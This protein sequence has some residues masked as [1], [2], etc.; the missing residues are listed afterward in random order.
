VDVMMKSSTSKRNAKEYMVKCIEQS[1]DMLRQAQTQINE[2]YLIYTIKQCCLNQRLSFENIS[3]SSQELAYYVGT[4]WTIYF[5]RPELWENITLTDI[6][7]VAQKYLTETNSIWFALMNR[8]HVYSQLKTSDED[9]SEEHNEEDKKE[10]EEEGDDDEKEFKK[11]LSRASSHLHQDQKLPSSRVYRHQTVCCNGCANNTSNGSSKS[12]AISRIN[13]STLKSSSSTTTTLGENE[14]L[15]FD[16]RIQSLKLD[17]GVELKYYQAYSSS[18][19]DDDSS[20]KTMTMDI[21]IDAGRSY[22]KQFGNAMFSNLAVCHMLYMFDYSAT[23]SIGLQFW[24]EI[25]PRHIIIHTKFMQNDLDQVVAAFTDC[26][27]KSSSFTEE[28]FK[29]SSQ[30][31]IRDLLYRQENQ[32]YRSSSWCFNKTYPV[33]HPCYIEKVQDS[34]VSI[35]YM[36]LFDSS[37]FFNSHI[38]PARIHVQIIGRKKVSLLT[39]AGVLF[40]KG[41]GLWNPLALS[42]KLP[43]WTPTIA[44]Q[45]LWTNGIVK[46]DQCEDDKYKTSTT[47]MMMQSTGLTMSRENI[48]QYYALRIV[49]AILGETSMSR[50]NFVFRQQRNLAYYNTCYVDTISNEEMSLVFMLQFANHMI[51]RENVDIVSLVRQELS[52]MLLQGVTDEELNMHKNFIINLHKTDMINASSISQYILRQSLTDKNVEDNEISR[53]LWLDNIVEYVKSITMDDIQNVLQKLDPMTMA[54]YCNTGMYSIDF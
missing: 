50:M 43:T 37:S 48:K 11:I 52:N 46:E 19:G 15:I 35:T 26:I 16:K 13:P 40:T 25:T 24:F 21:I 17:N 33:D 34:I 22:A 51:E 27:R 45:K 53:F 31:L 8:S 30:M 39:N 1:S 12:S 49:S 42:I 41:L 54:A 14:P 32:N 23:A 5:K 29:A 4:D 44:P 20:T 6:E 28:S 2:S 18:G 10:E 38:H 7:M 9:E 36:T 47:I 3:Q